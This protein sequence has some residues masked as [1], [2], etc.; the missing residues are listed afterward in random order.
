MEKLILKSNRTFLLKIILFALI[1]SLLITIITFMGFFFADNS[2]DILYTFVISFTLSLILL[3]ILCCIIF[4]KKQLS[5]LQ[6]K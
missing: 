3:I 5:F 1:P 6:K 2:N 4:I